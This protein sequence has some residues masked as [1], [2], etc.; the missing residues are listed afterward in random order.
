MSWTRSSAITLVLRLKMPVSRITRRSVMVKL[1]E[2]QRM[3]TRISANPRMASAASVA[4][5]RKSLG[6]TFRKSATAASTTS[7]T[8]SSS[9][10]TM[11]TQCCFSFRTRLSP[12]ISSSLMRRSFCPELEED[13]QC[14][15]RQE[16]AVG[17][18]GLHLQHPQD[19]QQKRDHAREEDAQEERADDG[20]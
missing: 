18:A 5:R 14:P 8:G 17:D 4:I 7:A 15:R 19:H 9:G 6:M 13:D 11:T 12:G 16:G 1:R 20:E 3:K 2:L 10:R